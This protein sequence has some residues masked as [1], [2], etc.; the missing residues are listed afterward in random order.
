MSKRDPHLV[1]AIKLAGGPGAVADACSIRSQAVS[2]W[3]RCPAER[4]LILEKLTGGK[5]SRHEIR[6]DLYPAEV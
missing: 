3:A 1:E 4:V 5:M 6:P 2:Q